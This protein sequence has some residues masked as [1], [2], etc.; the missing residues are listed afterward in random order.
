MRKS[1]LSTREPTQLNE[2]EENRR[3]TVPA[4]SPGN[5]PTALQDIKK[6]RKNL[7]NPSLFHHPKKKLETNKK[8]HPRNK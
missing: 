8:K 6:S 1:T 3:S 5:F 2:K 4:L 7:K